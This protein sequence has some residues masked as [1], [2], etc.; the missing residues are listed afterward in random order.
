MP[1][2]EYQCDACA[3]RF[4]VIQK[5]SDAPIDVCPKCGG[6]VKKLLSSPA[7]QFKGIGLV[8]HRLRAQGQ[9]QRDQPRQ[10]KR[11]P[12]SR[13]RI[14]IEVGNARPRR[15]AKPS[16]R[17]D[18]DE[19]KTTSRLK[20]AT[21]SVASGFSRIY[22]RVFRYSRNG[23]ASSGRFSAKYTLAFRNPS[24]L[25]VSWRTPSTSQ[26]VDRP[27]LQQM[28]QA[29]GELD[30]AGLVLRRVACSDAK[31]SGVRM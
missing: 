27:R 30:L 12:I 15:R 29:V 17:Q 3:H 21:R 14:G 9:R 4:E 16:R 20:P 25:P 31:M 11:R 13:A 10:A 18:R 2:Y 19:P 26:R 22:F 1:L 7:I 8:H 24:L 28:A 5:Y 6:A 23:P